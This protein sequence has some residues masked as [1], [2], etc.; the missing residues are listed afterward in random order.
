MPVSINCPKYQAS[1]EVA[2]YLL[3]NGMSAAQL[4]DLV[5]HAAPYTHEW[6]NRRFHR[7]LFQVRGMKVLRIDHL[8][9]D[10]DVE[11]ALKK[12]DNC[13]GKGCDGCRGGG[14]KPVAMPRRA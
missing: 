8:A 13:K 10:P 4:H 6:A 3:L 14:Y 2:R 5:A 12:C 9:L 1:A 11:Y 7:F